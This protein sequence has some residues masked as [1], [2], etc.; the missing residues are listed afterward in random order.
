MLYKLAVLALTAFTLLAGQASGA[1][2]VADNA[3]D[4][5]NGHNH[6][7]EGH[8]CAFKTGAGTANGL[9]DC[10]WNACSNLVCVA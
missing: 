9:T 6:Y 4:A 7:G 8:S 3:V 2:Q 1:A 5:C 10:R